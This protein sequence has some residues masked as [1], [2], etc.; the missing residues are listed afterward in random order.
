[1]INH[2]D[3]PNLFVDNEHVV[4]FH[5]VNP[6]LP[7]WLQE[8]LTLKIGAGDLQRGNVLDIELFNEYDVFYC[9]PWNDHKSFVRNVEY[10][11][12]NYYHEK[13]ICYIDNTNVEQIKKFAKLFQ[14]RFV[15]ISRFAGHCPQLPLEVYS[16]ILRIGGKIENYAEPKDGLFHANDLLNS[17]IFSTDMTLEGTNSNSIMSNTLRKKIDIPLS[18]LLCSH[19]QGDKKNLSI[20]FRKY[21]IQKKER[22]NQTIHRNIYDT[23]D[24]IDFTILMRI[25]YYVYIAETLP[26]TLHLEIGPDA[27]AYLIRIHTTNGGKKSQRTRAKRYKTNRTR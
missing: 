22:A 7:D 14:N 3:F 12:A 9:L 27:T 13:I 15:F 10:I 6:T 4:N 20:V 2:L 26:P 16:K 11:Q 17:F 21:L 24:T 25:V 1:M 19:V 23:L 8:S 18:I 5:S